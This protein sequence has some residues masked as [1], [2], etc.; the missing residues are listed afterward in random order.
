MVKINDKKLSDP[1]GDG[2]GI[3]FAVA[4]GDHELWAVKGFVE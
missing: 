3:G 2:R 1:E 4:D